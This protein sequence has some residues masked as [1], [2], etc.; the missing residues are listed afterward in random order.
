MLI[1][2]NNTRQELEDLQPAISVAEACSKDGEIVGVIVSLLDGMHFTCSSFVCDEVSR[3]SSV[4]RAGDDTICS[5]FFAPWAGIPEDPV[6]GSAHSV[7]AA[8]YCT[9]KG[10]QSMPAR[11][12]SKRGGELDITLHAENQTVDV[13]GHAVTTVA[14]TMF[15]P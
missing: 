2:C 9:S 6:T 15:V 11:Q 12:C 7:L 13:S 3:N 5:R 10:Q 8:F 4:A 1:V 14:G